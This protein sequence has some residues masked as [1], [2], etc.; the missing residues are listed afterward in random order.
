MFHRSRFYYVP[1]H[2]HWVRSTSTWNRTYPSK[3]ALPTLRANAEGNVNK[4][5]QQHCTYNALHSDIHFYCEPSKNSFNQVSILLDMF[6]TINNCS[7]KC[8]FV[9]ICSLYLPANAQLPGAN[10]LIGTEGDEKKRL[11]SIGSISDLHRR[12]LGKGEVESSFDNEQQALLLYPC[13]KCLW[14]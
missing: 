1:D 4:S 14:E 12:A 5:N 3:A 9:S 6:C 7:P 2:H 8:Y 13:Q 10:T 11:V